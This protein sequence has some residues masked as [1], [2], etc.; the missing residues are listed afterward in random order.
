MRRFRFRLEAVLRHRRAVLRESQRDFA[1]ARAEQASVEEQIRR[2]RRS[3]DECQEEIR[4]AAE[5]ELSRTRLLRL[6]TYANSLWLGLLRA[7]QQLGELAARTAERRGAMVRARQGVRAL[8]T[9]REKS[10][11]AWRADA[12]R[13]E[14]TFLDD[15]RPHRALLEPP[16]ARV[17]GGEA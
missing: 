15:L 14:R 11:R 17:A 8:E 4:R 2:M 5:G 3:R 9:L 13:E 6:R 1:L 7:G 16:T 10:F 12:D